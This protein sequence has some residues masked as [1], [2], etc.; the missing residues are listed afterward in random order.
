MTHHTPDHARLLT[1]EEASECLGIG[2]T[3]A[4]ELV[5][6]GQLA[7]IKIGTRR[8]IAVTSLTRYISDALGVIDAPE[9]QTKGALESLVASGDVQSIT[10]GKYVFVS[11]DALDTY[12]RRQSEVAS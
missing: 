9:P 7:S 10:L 12:T 5:M 4:Y 1:V 3:K 11:V 2:R 6:S 8:L